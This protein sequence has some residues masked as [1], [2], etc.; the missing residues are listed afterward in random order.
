MASSQGPCRRL[1]RGL[2]GQTRLNWVLRT[3]VCPL[4]L[5]TAPLSQWQARATNGGF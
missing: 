5:W 4:G 1:S 3:A 2:L